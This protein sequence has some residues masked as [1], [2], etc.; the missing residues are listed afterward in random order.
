MLLHQADLAVAAVHS[1]DRFVVVDLSTASGGDRLGDDHAVQ[2]AGAADGD[3]RVRDVDVG[4]DLAG[5]GGLLADAG[6][7]GSVDHR[8]RAHESDRPVG[9]DVA[10]AFLGRGGVGAVVGVPAV[11]V[12]RALEADRIDPDDRVAQGR[13]GA[14]DRLGA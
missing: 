7:C 3:V 10:P 8:R 5:A 6:V 12:S 4:V 13:V 1:G 14:G 2:V 9:G 11:D